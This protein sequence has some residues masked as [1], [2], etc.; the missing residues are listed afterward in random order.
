M[1][2]ASEQMH[3]G[4]RLQE[5]GIALIVQFCCERVYQYGVSF[6]LYSTREAA[7]GLAGGR[8]VLTAHW[9]KALKL[10]AETNAARS[11]VA[12]ILRANMTN[13]GDGLACK[14]LIE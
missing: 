1:K 14:K 8:W 11:A 5:F 9:G 12:T 4:S 7:R 10:W 6:L 2:P 3:F 13:S